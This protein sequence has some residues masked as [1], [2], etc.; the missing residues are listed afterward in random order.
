MKVIF[1]HIPKAGGTTL[2]SVLERQYGAAEILTLHDYEIPEIQRLSPEQQK[3]IKLIRGH[4]WYGVHRHFQEECT[5]ITLLRDPVERIISH[6]FYIKTDPRHYLY[7][8]IQDLNLSLADYAMSDLSGELDNGQLR[9]ISGEEPPLGYCTEDMLT[10]AK[11]NIEEHFS[12]VGLTER[13]D[14]SVALMKIR[15]GWPRSIHYT[16]RNV[17]SAGARKEDLWAKLR[18]EIRE[19]NWLDYKLYEWAHERLAEQLRANAL[20]VGLQVTTLRV[21][22]FLTTLN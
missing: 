17:S 3:R 19:R 5:Y 21:R 12:V 6:Y 9:L 15:L 13:F 11:V 4:F 7:G 10:K 20:R 18:M 14:A 1:L 16:K 22:N 2:Y 8:K